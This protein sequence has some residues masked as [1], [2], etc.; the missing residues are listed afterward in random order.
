MRIQQ[1]T[2][3]DGFRQVAALERELWGYADAEDAVPAPMLALTSKIGGLL[4]GAFDDEGRLC[5]FAYSLPGIRDGRAFHWSHLLGVVERCRG[6]G[7][8]HRL[9]CEQ[10]R[11][12][13]EM[14]LDLIEWTFDP[15]QATNA[16]LNLVKLGVVVREYIENVYEDSSSPLHAATETDRLLAEW[17]ITS[18][19]VED[20]LSASATA[21]SQRDWRPDDVAAVNVV[22]RA[23]RWIAPGAHDLGMDDGRLAVHIPMGFTE[24]QLEAVELAR[25]WR[26]STRAV[27]KTY[28]PRGYDVVDFCLQPRD[29][30][31]TYL[32]VRNPE[33]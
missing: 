30:R 10:R 29:G 7:L 8:G 18:P 32:L 4:L 16:H 12:A 20:R 28:L 31:G 17:W 2:D 19:E 1:L 3:T 22:C 26:A 27:F 13:L 11:L 6:Q 25:A 5:G 33:R 23:D 15:L 9:K 24:M 21:A 14:G